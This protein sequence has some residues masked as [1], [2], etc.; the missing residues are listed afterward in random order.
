MPREAA[1]PSAWLATQ[2]ASQLAASVGQQAEQLA[3][4]V[5]LHIEDE[6]STRQQSLSTELVMSVI[7]TQNIT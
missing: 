3:L 4:Q 5:A 1:T 6:R 7:F 2:L